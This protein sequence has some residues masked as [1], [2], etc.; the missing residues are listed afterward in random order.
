MTTNK[1]KRRYLQ[2]SLR[3][4]FVLLTLFCVVAGWRM[5]QLRR[6]W[7]AVEWVREN[8]GRV[9]YSMDDFEGDILSRYELRDVLWVV[10]GND[11]FS[12]LTPLANL[13]NLESLDLYGTEVSDLTPLANL[14]NLEYLGLYGA[15]VSDLTPLANLTNLE[16]LSIDGTEV[17]DLTPLANLTNLED[18][19]LDDTEVSD[20]TPLANLMNLKHLRLDG[21][22]VNA[23]CIRCSCLR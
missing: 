2:F 16:V 12:D 17:S 5:N 6:Q 8:G 4:F 13:T 23:E 10:V 7:E 18:L 15:E 19:Y 9:G 1:P 20:L 21:T 22:E 3:T 11:T 14:T